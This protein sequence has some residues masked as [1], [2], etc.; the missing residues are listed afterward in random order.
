[1]FNKYIFVGC[2]DLLLDD[3]KAKNGIVIPLDNS[4]NGYKDSGGGMFIA[5]STPFQ[6]P[7]TPWEHLPITPHSWFS[8]NTISNL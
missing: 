8:S 3:E 4:Y 2:F 1:M 6:P 5:P 7:M